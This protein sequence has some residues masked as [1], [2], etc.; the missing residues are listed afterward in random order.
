[1]SQPPRLLIVDDDY[2][3]TALLERILVKAG[4]EVIVAAD[5]HAALERFATDWAF[6]TVLLDRQMPGL[7]GMQVLRHMKRTEELKDIPVV[8]QSAMDSEE[9]INDGT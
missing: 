8:F 6:D 9:E 4:Y 2:F 3:I 1:M 5:G 7:D